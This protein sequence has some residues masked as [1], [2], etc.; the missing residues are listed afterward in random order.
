MTENIK[1]IEVF[2]KEIKKNNQSFIAYKAKKKDGTFISC[3]FTRDCENAPDFEGLGKIRVHDKD[4]NVSNSGF[5]PA[6]WVRNVIEAWKESKEE[7][8]SDF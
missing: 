1:E 7:N 6:L 2:G 5:Y 3:K 4:C 8:L